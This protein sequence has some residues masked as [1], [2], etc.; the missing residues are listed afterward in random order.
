[1]LELMKWAAWTAYR[2]FSNILQNEVL[3]PNTRYLICSWHS[4]RSNYTHCVWSPF[5]LLRIK[6]A[7]LRQQ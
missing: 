5:Q 2:H 7:E 1:L 3:R 6:P 4:D